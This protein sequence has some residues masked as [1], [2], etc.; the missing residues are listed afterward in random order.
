MPGQP[1]RPGLAHLFGARP[2]AVERDGTEGRR[3]VLN[4]A[5]RGASREA[6]ENTLPAFERAIEASADAIEADVRVTADGHAVVLHDATLERTT[7]GRGRV[8]RLALAEVRALDAGG[9][10]RVPTVREVLDLARGRAL[11]MLEIKV[12][13]AVAPTIDAVTSAGMSERVALMAFSARS[14]RQA[15][16]LAPQIPRVRLAR[17]RAEATLA[18]RS[19]PGSC[20]GARHRIVDA[21]LLERCLRAHRPVIAWTVDEERDLRRLIDLGVDALVTN[22]PR[23][24]ASLLGT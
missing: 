21:V 22:E 18:L 15:R 19:D 6:P 14:L 2:D 16:A 13:A 20:L 5:H 17:N 11:V 3:R 8:G 4:V 24:L 1:S 10:A 7:E 23:R 12:L 9:G